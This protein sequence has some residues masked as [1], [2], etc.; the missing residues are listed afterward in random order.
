MIL[1]SKKAQAT[2][3]PN[4]QYYMIMNNFCKG[5]TTPAG[6]TPENTEYGIV[7]QQNKR[8]FNSKQFN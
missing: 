3:I 8:N 1:L 2:M 7:E 4:I 6:G 5:D